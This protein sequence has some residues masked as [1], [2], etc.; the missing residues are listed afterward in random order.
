M[1]DF[2]SRLCAKTARRSAFLLLHTVLGAPKRHWGKGKNFHPAA[3]QQL[4]SLLQRD[5]NDSAHRVVLTGIA[6]TWKDSSR[7]CVSAA[8]VP[9]AHRIVLPDPNIRR[10][11]VA[12]SSNAVELCHEIQEGLH[13][14]VSVASRK[15]AL[16][17]SSPSA[18]HQVSQR[19]RPRLQPLSVP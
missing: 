7:V 13:A 4:F 6:V 9:L 10:T 11:G 15:G 2:F 8:A 19:H 1:S 17:V 5:A 12:S 3:Q 18:L 14:A 16:A